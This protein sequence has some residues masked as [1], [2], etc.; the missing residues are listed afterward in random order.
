[1]EKLSGFMEA[2]FKEKKSGNMSQAE[3]DV[4]MAHRVSENLFWHQPVRYPELHGAIRQYCEQRKNGQC[5]RDAD[6]HKRVN[7]FVLRC[8]RVREEN[9]ANL[10]TFVWAKAKL[11]GANL[12]QRV[13]I[14]DRAMSHFDSTGHRSGDIALAAETLEKDSHDLSLMAR[15]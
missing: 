13:E 6:F 7:E 10:S 3:Y 9:K 5:Q 12:L 14:L 4:F 15:R 1:M 2:I 8:V 11:V